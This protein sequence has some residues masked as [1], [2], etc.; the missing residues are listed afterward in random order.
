MSDRGGR[1]YVMYGQTE[2]APRISTLDHD[3]FLEHRGSVGRAIPGG[4]LSIRDEVGIELPAGQEG[5]IWY[6]GPNVM[7][8]YAESFA[9]LSKGDELAGVLAT[10]DVGRLGDGGHLTITGRVKRMGKVYGLRV[11]LDEV[12]RLVKGVHAQS[13]VVQW[14]EKI[15]VVLVSSQDDAAVLIEKVRFELVRYYTI[16][17]SAFEFRLVDEIPTTNRGKV[18]YQRLQAVG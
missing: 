9:D 14:G 5:I 10:G 13:A 1:F 6:E 7:M 16:P 3:D 2:A 18:D 4:R 17:V 8:G 12:E 11:N 15:A